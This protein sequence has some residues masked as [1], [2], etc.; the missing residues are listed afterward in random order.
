MDQPSP[1]R[2][3]GAI[4]RTRRSQSEGTDVIRNATNIRLATVLSGAGR[5][6]RIALA[7]LS[8]TGGFCFALAAG[9]ASASHVGCGDTVTIDT[10]LDSDLVNCPNNGIEIGA[11]DIA[12]DLNGHTIDGDEPEE[13]AEICDVGVV[14]FDHPGVTITG[15]SVREF[16]LGLVVGGSTDNRLLDLSAARN[17]FM[18]AVLADSP[19]AQLE[20]NTVVENGLHTDREGL[21]L[22]GSPHSR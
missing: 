3:F 12:L 2:R 15:G 22:F 8:L 20:R 9:Q 16:A 18:G 7:I 17:T 6:S 4:D 1:G 10:R 13:C 14:N 11:D 5:Q 21:G 19:R